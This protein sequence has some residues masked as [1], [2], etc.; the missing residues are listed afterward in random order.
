VSSQALDTLA[1]LVD[2]P[3]PAIV[4]VVIQ[5]LTTVY[6]LLFRFLYVTGGANFNPYL[7]TARPD[8][9]TEAITLL[10]TLLQRARPA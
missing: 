6:P 5:C 3:N 8:A 4:K 10:G 1:Q 2:D 7:L 9:P